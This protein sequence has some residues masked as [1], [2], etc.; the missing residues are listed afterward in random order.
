MIVEKFIKIIGIR[1]KINKSFID[2]Y[3]LTSGAVDNYLFENCEINFIKEICDILKSGKSEKRQCIVRVTKDEEHMVLKLL[4]QCSNQMERTILV[5]DFVNSKIM[6]EVYRGVNKEEFERCSKHLSAFYNADMWCAKE[7]HKDGVV[8]PYD[9][10]N[11]VKNEHKFDLNVVFEDIESFE[12]QRA[13]N[14]YMSARLPLS[15]KFFHTSKMAS[16]ADETLNLIQS[17]H[18]FIS[19]NP[20][21]FIEKIN[22][23]ENLDER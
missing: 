13:F 9:I 8:F 3:L 4:S 11:F 16:Y 2:N 21:N 23:S 7:N 22:N 18:D 17:P 15:V 5:R 20:N 12:I 10:I 14:N 19:V 1:M 6:L